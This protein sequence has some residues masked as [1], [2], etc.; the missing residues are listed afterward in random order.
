MTPESP[1]LPFPGAPALASQWVPALE[2][3]LF[4]SADPMSTAAL[5]KA[6]GDADSNQV[7]QALAVLT[8]R[9]HRPESGVRLVQV[10]DGWQL[11]TDPRFAAQV[12]RAKQARPVTLGPAALE[13]LAGVAYQQPVTRQELDALRGVDC[14]GVL[15]KCVDRGLVKVVGRRTLPGRPLEYGTTERFLQL[16]SLRTLSDL[17]TLAERETMTRHQLPEPVG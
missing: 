13:V 9:S 6:L 2:A 15:K 11:Q 17:P 10:A 14:G 12:L 16:F 7:R 4:A 5:A 3:V 8:E 1:T